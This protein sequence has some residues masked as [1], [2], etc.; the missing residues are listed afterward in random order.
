MD[1]NNNNWLVAFVAIMIIVFLGIVFY[2]V[3]SQNDETTQNEQV[4]C[5]QEAKLCPDGSYVG[6][7]GPACEFAECPSANDDSTPWEATSTTEATFE[8]PTSLSSAYL[9]AA[10][11]PPSVQVVDEEFSCTEAG[12]PT[13]RA[14]ATTEE[15]INGRQY[16]VTE[17]R[18]GAAGSMYSEYAYAFPRDDKTVILTFSIRAPQCGN[19]PEPQK[20]TCT[21]DQNN[22]NLNDLVDRVAE[23]LELKSA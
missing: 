12:E 3:Y 2:V 10:D 17:V 15:T 6:R 1:K 5:T 11:W 13:D 20:T 9:T 16:C 8:Y 18:E 14:G 22:F 7:T 4:A 23:T 21:K 19:Y